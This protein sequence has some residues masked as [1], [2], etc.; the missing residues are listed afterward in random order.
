MGRLD[1]DESMLPEDMWE[2]TLEED[3]FE[4]EKIMD[5]RSGRKT[6]FRRI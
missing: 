3:E 6:H 4:V 1:S 2:R 5:V